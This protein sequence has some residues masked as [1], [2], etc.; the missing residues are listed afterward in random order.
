MSAEPSKKEYLPVTEKFTGKLTLK[1]AESIAPIGAVLSTMFICCIY[2]A[3]LGHVSWL[4]MMQQWCRL[5]SEVCILH[6]HIVYAIALS[7]RRTTLQMQCVSWSS[8]VDSCFVA[9]PRQRAD[10]HGV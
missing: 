3:G 1:Q 4:Q 8:G 7:R 5:K 10:A 6:V 2:D 9:S